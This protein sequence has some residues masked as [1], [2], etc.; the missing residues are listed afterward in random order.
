MIDFDG[1]GLVDVMQTTPTQYYYWRNNGDGSWGA[2]LGG[3]PIPNQTVAFSQF[4]RPS[5]RHELATA[6]VDLVDVRA[7]AIVYWPN[8]GAGAGGAARSPLPARP[9]RA[10]IRKSRVSSWPT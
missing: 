3:A 5:R 10:R 9:T 1:D 4:P 2:P 6:C 8:L 7:G